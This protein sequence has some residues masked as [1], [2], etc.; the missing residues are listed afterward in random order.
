MNAENAHQAFDWL[1]IAE[2]LSTRGIKSVIKLAPP[3]ASNALS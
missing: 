2:Q 3:T 1:W